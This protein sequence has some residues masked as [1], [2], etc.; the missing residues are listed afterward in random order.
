MCVSNS[1]IRKYY[2]YCSIDQSCPAFCDSMDCSPPASSVHDYS[3]QEFWSGLSF[4][5]P[6][7]SSWPRD[8]ICLLHWQADPLPLSQRRSLFLPVGSGAGKF[9]NRPM[10]VST[11][12]LTRPLWW[13]TSS[14]RK[15]CLNN[16]ESSSMNAWIHI[17][18]PCI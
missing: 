3:R 1:I 6:G 2:W 16:S 12:N 7:E 11:S 14:W 5:S 10:S 13:L 17:L 18:A 15:L 9:Q 8:Q 4:S